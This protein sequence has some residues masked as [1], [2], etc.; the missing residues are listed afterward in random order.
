ME[1]SNSSTSIDQGSKPAEVAETSIQEQISNTIDASTQ[2]DQV[3]NQYL[4]VETGSLLAEEFAASHTV[5]MSV[6]NIVPGLPPIQ[7]EQLVMH[8]SQC[9]SRIAHHT[10]NETL[11]VL[12]RNE[13][14]LD[15]QIISEVLATNQAAVA[16]GYAA[17]FD[18]AT[19]L[20][21]SGGNSAIVPPELLNQ[22]DSVT[23]ATVAYSQS[24]LSHKESQQL[25][26]VI[27]GTITYHSITIFCILLI[28]GLIWFFFPLQHRRD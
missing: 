10:T 9:T 21:N 28:S 1:G 26:S 11:Q 3:V 6:Q 14:P 5:N 15:S 24:M 4:S 13:I 27:E 16:N 17:G 23:P 12:Y 2:T 22:I 25:S 18:G 7:V 19:R 20:L 8:G